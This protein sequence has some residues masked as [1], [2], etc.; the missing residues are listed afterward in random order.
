MVSM[1][2]KLKAGWERFLGF[3]QMRGMDMIGVVFVFMF[4]IRSQ[5]FSLLGHGFIVLELSILWQ[6]NEQWSA[7]IM[8]IILF[9][10]S[11]FAILWNLF[12]PFVMIEYRFE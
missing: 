12:H 3:S 6:V 2:R 7:R 8:Y 9:L 11:V 5:L 10:Y 4:L 1:I